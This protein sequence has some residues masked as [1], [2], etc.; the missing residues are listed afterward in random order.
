LRLYTKSHGVEVAD[1]L[2]AA[3]AFLENVPLGTLNRKHYPMKDL[4]FF[5][6]GSAM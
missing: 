2:V 6:T 5:P 1:A 4:S 3:C